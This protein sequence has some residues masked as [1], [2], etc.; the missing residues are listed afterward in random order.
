MHIDTQAR[1]FI[2]SGL[3]AVIVFGVWMFF[4]KLPD[5]LR[6]ISARNAGS[7]EKKSLQ[8]TSTSSAQVPLPPQIQPLKQS[9]YSIRVGSTNLM[10]EVAETNTEKA[11]GL[12]FRESLPQNQGLIF[13][14][15]TA[16]K[17][18]FWMKDM[19]FPIDIIWIGSD[20][21]V[22]DITPNLDPNTYPKLFAPKEPAM[23]V[24]ETNTSF[25]QTHGIHI[26]DSVDI[27]SIQ[28]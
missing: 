17:Y 2:I 28:K 23:Y 24:L 9:L 7:S 4:A 12:S 3:I 10:A 13:L 25:A 20:K 1:N 21:T 18:Q 19:R 8:N 11:R 14:F 6:F 27:S 16:E 26:G 22:V 15:D 5:A